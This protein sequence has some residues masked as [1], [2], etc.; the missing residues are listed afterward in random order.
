MMRWSTS[1]HLI[2]DLADVKY[3]PWKLGGAFT[4]ACEEPINIIYLNSID[5]AK[6]STDVFAILDTETHD[7]VLASKGSGDGVPVPTDLSSEWDFL[8]RDRLLPHCKACQ[9]PSSHVGH[10]NLPNCRLADPAKAKKKIDENYFE[11]ALERKAQHNK[12]AIEQGRAPNNT[13]KKGPNK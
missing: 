10:T 8:P 13:H 11:K 3:S 5:V 12:N 6:H 4:A 2:I 1:G 9:N 7:D